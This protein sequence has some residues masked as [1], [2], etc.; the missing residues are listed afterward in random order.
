M[1]ILTDKY[2]IKEINKR[3]KALDLLL[4]KDNVPLKAVLKD[5]VDL[6]INTFSVGEHIV[7]TGKMRKRKD[8]MFLDVIR[9][10][11][12]NLDEEDVPQQQ[13]YTSQEQEDEQWHLPYINRFRELRS[14]VKDV[15]YKKLLDDFFGNEEMEGMFFETPGA[16]GNHHNYPFG[17]LQHT[18]EVTNIALFIANQHSQGINFDLLITGCLLHDVGKMRSYDY[19]E[20]DEIIRTDWDKF[21][22]HL[23]MS[24]IFVSKMIKPDFDKHKA[25]LLYHLI[26]SHHGKREWG[27]PVEPVMKEAAILHTADMNSFNMNHIDRLKYEDNWAED[28]LQRTKWY[29]E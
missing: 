14:M 3:R 11:K 15:D 19:T 5:N 4:E 16:K 21:I 27:S 6:F 1:K 17:L 28:K 13:T 24:A 2:L 18:I 20:E 26:L 25:M 9:V 22:G 8:E 23:T 10:K 12:F 7:A 29:K